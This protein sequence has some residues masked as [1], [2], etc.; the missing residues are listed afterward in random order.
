MAIKINIPPI[1]ILF[2]KDCRNIW[3]VIL[4]LLLLYGSSFSMKAPPRFNV[5]NGAVNIDEI[6]EALF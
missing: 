2:T 4:N 3:E 1:R 6:L 5:F